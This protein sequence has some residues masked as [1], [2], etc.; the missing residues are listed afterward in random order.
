MRAGATALRF[1]TSFLAPSPT[2]PVYHAPKEVTLELFK[3]FAAGIE[4]VR[5]QKLGKP[6]GTSAPVAKP[7]LAAFWRS[8]LA[9]AN[10]IGNLQGVRLLFAKGGFAQVVA[11]DSPGVEDL[12]LFDLNHAI[13]VLGGMDKAFAEVAADETLRAKLEALRVSLKSA[14]QTAGAII[15]QSAGLS[16][17]FNAMDGD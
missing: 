5:D 13:E 7:R 10:M 17:G 6:L 14:G 1:A 8:N 9:F 2:D 16:F 15:A 11:A 3:S 12:I 4:L